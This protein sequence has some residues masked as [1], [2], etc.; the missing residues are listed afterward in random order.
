M[1]EFISVFISELLENG[2]QLA[3]TWRQE[4]T[5]GAVDIDDLSETKVTK[6]FRLNKNLIRVLIE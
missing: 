3:N 1:D 2:E 4:R 5:Y 6:N